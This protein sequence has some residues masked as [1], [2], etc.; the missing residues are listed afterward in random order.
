MT[1]SV[2][3]RCKEVIPDGELEQLDAYA[4]IELCQKCFQLFEMKFMKG[5]LI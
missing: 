4:T 5:L 1:C 3:D 2:C